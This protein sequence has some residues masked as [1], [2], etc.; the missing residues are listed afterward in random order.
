MFSEDSE[1]VVQT[2]EFDFL[3][4]TLG[5]YW[6]WPKQTDQ[7]IVATK[8]VFHGPCIPNPPTRREFQF[9]DEGRAKD[10]YRVLKKSLKL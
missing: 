1:S 9:P 10:L 5:G 7:K 4:P 6:D 2:V 8:F 3:H